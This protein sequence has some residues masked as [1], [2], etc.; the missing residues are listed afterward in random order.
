[1]LL[2]PGQNNR[3]EYPEVAAHGLV[4]AVV[5][6]EVTAKATVWAKA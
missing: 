3:K 4:L 5:K 1:P 2:L 6:V